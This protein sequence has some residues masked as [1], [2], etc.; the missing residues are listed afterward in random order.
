MEYIREV[1][2]ETP[3]GAKTL[4]ISPPDANGRRLVDH[5]PSGPG[6]RFSNFGFVAAEI[7]GL[8]VGRILRVKQLNYS[9]DGEGFW[10]EE[11][12]VVSN[13]MFKP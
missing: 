10:R 3:Q 6:T 1:V 4:Y 11:G 5:R 7:K 2:V 12:R 8:R 13:R 9:K